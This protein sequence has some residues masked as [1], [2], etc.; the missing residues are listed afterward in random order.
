FEP[1]TTWRSTVGIVGN[2]S[3]PKWV[4][5][6]NLAGATTVDVRYSAN[7]SLEAAA[8]ISGPGS[9]TKTGV[10]GTLSIASVSTYTGGTNVDGGTILLRGRDLQSGAG[11]IRGPVVLNTGTTLRLATDQVLGT[12]PGARVSPLHATGALVESTA[13]GAN[14]LHVVKLSASTIR[15]TQGGNSMDATGY[16]QMAAGGGLIDVRPSSAPSVISGRLDLGAG[17][18][19]TT[20]AVAEGPASDDLSVNA[21]ITG[22]TPGQGMTKSG[23]GRML[24]GSPATFTGLTT[25][26]EGGLLLGRDGTLPSSPVTVKG[27]G[28]FGTDHPGKSLAALTVEAHGQI[29]L[30]AKA[31]STTVINGPLHF[32]EGNFFVSPVLGAGATTG[33]IDLATADSI[34]GSGLPVLAMDGAYGPNRATGT[35]AVN[36]NKLQLTLTSTGGELVWNNDSA[37]GSR[38]GIWDTNLENFS[39]SGAS[40]A[41]QS[42]DRVTFNDSVAPGENKYVSVTQT[43]APALI[44]VD[45]SN[46]D[47]DFGNTG[48]LTGVGSLLKTGSATLSIGATGGYPLTGDIT[49]AGGVIQFHGRTILIDKLTLSGG[50]LDGA[51]VAFKSADFQSGSSSATLTGA[52]P[53]MKTTSGKAILTGNNLLTGPGIVAEGI[54]YVNAAVSRYTGYSSP[55]SLGSSQVHIAADAAVCVAIHDNDSVVPNTFSGT[56]SLTLAGSNTGRFPYSDSR[57]RLT[58]D[59]SGF[60][61]TIDLVSAT[62]TPAPATLGNVRVRLGGNAHLNISSQIFANA[63]EFVNTAPDVSTLDLLN[64]TQTGPVSLP[65]GGTARITTYSTG[66]ISGPIQDSGGPGS[67]TFEGAYPRDTFSTENKLTLSGVSTYTGPTTVTEEGVLN[68]TGSLGDTAVTVTSKGTIG[69]NGSI[70]TGGS[71]TFQQDGRLWVKSTGDTLTVNGDVDLGTRT[72][73]VVDLSTTP[74]RGPFPVLRYAGTLTGGTAEMA[75]EVSVPYRQAVFGFSPGLITLDIGSKSVIWKGQS[76]TRWEPGSAP[77]WSTDGTAEA[78]S[79]YDGD[80]VTFDDTGVTQSVTG[81]NLSVRPASTLFDNSTKDY[82]IG[83]PILGA[84]KITKRGTGIVNLSLGSGHTGG[85]FIEAGTL[86]ANFLGTGPV[87]VS[88]GAT[89]MGAPTIGLFN[90]A[91]TLDP[92]IPGG[93]GASF[94]SGPAVFS[95]VYQCLLDSYYASNHRNCDLFTVKGDL[96]LTGSTLAITKLPPTSGPVEVYTI[97]TYTGNLTGDFACVTGMPEDYKLVH[98]VANKSFIIIHKPFSEWIDTFANLSDRAPGGDPDGDGISNIAEYVLGGNPG[99]GDTLINPSYELTKD[100]LVFRY[101]RRDS[102]IYNTTQVVQWSTDMMTWNDRV[103]SARGSS[104]VFITL[105]GELPD[106]VSVYINRPPGQKIFARLKVTPK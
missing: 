36:G 17:P 49:A 91:G 27:Y 43:I 40:T 37:A 103:V 42:F 92:G 70:G 32:P 100:Y 65:K 24:L 56:G 75:T 99:V 1:S 88:A 46:G 38:S 33:V 76:H 71:L 2:A 90:C 60:Q 44:T 5:P 62:L 58:G 7:L 80:D 97:L 3:S 101:K 26:E 23:S 14:T 4:G 48:N 57:C 64:S 45:N 20:F 69:G 51:I 96:D 22:S 13:T 79:Y 77:N 35:I 30:P 8:V 83:V 63:V 78:E 25:V 10:G 87:H 74:P 86:Q 67:V 9:I 18:E 41:F 95:G 6:V 89:L 11:A 34:T 93:T 84:G 47:Y 102:S 104:P 39:L 59:Y 81:Q 61:G 54:L 12:A 19:P 82:N 94:T 50:A 66:T 21:S 16:F 52:S 28:A 55:G 73:V 68:L 85:T 15:S 53:W 72:R 98:D 105:N 31:G 29:L 106:D